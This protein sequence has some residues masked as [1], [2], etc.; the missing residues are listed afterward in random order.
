MQTRTFGR[1]Q[2]TLP[3]LDEPGLYLSN[4]TSLESGRGHV[5][6][7]QYTDASLRALDL[8]DT[9]LITG[10]I[11]NLRASRVQLQSVNLH[12]VDFDSCDL[13]SVQWSESKLSRAVFRNCKIMG[14]DLASLALDDVLFEN[15]KLDYTAFSR[16]RATGPVVF[17]G[18][19]LAEASFTG[20]D[21]SNTVIRECSLRETEFRSGRYHD[22][23]LRDTDLSTVRGITHLKGIT[24]G[25]AQQPQLTQALLTELAV[26]YGDGID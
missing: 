22:L 25:R 21:L 8:A 24:I 2:L 19:S 23:D 5:Q 13:G 20:C 14:A 10:R 3:A 17:T 12:A 15:C 26:T 1:L 4:V 18:C 11:T 6:D 9:Q 7:F 16:I